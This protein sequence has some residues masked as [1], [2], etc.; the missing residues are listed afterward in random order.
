MKL[1]SLLVSIA[2]SQLACFAEDGVGG[3][4]QAE[5]PADESTHEGVDGVFALACERLH[6]ECSSVC[7]NVFVECYD[8]VDTC[9]EQWRLDYLADYAAPIV[10]E[11]LVQR[12]A[13]QVDEQS[14]TDLRPDTVE[15]DYSI[16]DS[17][18][19]DA[20]AHGAIYSPFSP[21]V[22]RVGD[23]IEVELCA[24]VEEY[25]AIELEAGAILDAVADDDVLVPGFIERVEMVTTPDGDT[26]IERSNLDTPAAHDGTY[27][28]A[29]ESGMAGS[30]RF[31]VVP[32][33]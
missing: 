28:L 25:F 17:C 15:C 22:A 6:G 29:V 26:V 32:A 9:T 12:C 2:L 21:G 19:G 14:C 20:D 5:E 7:D 18:V 27:L 3:A 31:S 4:A 10:D 30:F 16:V 33:Q 24:W 1:E 23:V 13:A 8:D 11:E